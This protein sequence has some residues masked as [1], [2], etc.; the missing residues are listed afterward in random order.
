M[1]SQ[2]DINTMQVLLRTH[3]QTLGILL[4]QQAKLGVYAPAGVLIGIAEARASIAQAKV[5]LRDW[6]VTVDDLPNDQSSEAPPVAPGP[7]GAPPSAVAASGD[8]IIGTVGAGAQGVAIGKQITQVLGSPGTPGDDRHAIDALLQRCEHELA[9]AGLDA[10][11]IGM[12]EFQLGLLAGE[13]RKLDP[14]ATPSAS[15]VSQVGGWLLDNLPPL[16][17]ALAALFAAPAVRR[18]LGRA[19]ADLSGW[20]QRR[21]GA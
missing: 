8:V 15:T 14:R 13:L 20:L 10:T 3:R 1:P 12:A 4:E 9:A 2:D 21:F 16:R 7:A 18:V 5:A 19:D 17:E 6:G 11:L